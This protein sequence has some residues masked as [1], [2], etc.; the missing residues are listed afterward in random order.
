MSEGSGAGGSSP[1]KFNP[2]SR[3]AKDEEQSKGEDADKTQ[4]DRKAEKLELKEKMRCAQR[5]KDAMKQADHE[6]DSTQT[7][8]EDGDEEGAEQ[9]GRDGLWIEDSVKDLKI[10]TIG[11]V[12]SGKSTLVGVLTKGL[13][14]DGRGKARSRVFN[15][16]HEQEKGQTSSIAQEIMGFS[17]SGD[18]V[19]VDRPGAVTAQSRNS[20]WQQI[21]NESEKLVTFIDLC[22]HERYLKTTIFGLVGLCP[23]YAM[24]I[25][26]ANAG[27]QKMSREHLGIALALRIPFMFIVTK[28]DIAPANV[29][30]ENLNMLRKIAKS[31]AVKKQ[32]VDIKEESDLEPAIKGLAADSLCP[33]FCISSVT[34]EG[35]PLLKRFIQSLPSRIEHSGL[36]RPPSAPTEHHIDSVFSVPGVGITVGGLMRAGVV[37]PNQQLLLG[38]DKSSKFTPVLVKSIHYKRVNSQQVESGQ[39]CS[40]ALRSLVKKEQ[41]KKSSFRKGMVLVDAALQPKATWVFKAEVVILHH[42]TTIRERYQ[43]MIHCGIVRQC[44]F[45]INLST[46]L[47]RTGD[48]AIVTFR[49]CFH[50]EYLNAGSTLLFREGRTKGI[51]R[52]VEL[53]DEDSLQEWGIPIK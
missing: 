25:V 53:V 24:I 18:Q 4:Q 51:G 21:V 7:P 40:F 11:N 19:I 37:R 33:I 39:H 8:S 46:D 10:A 49:F 28:I 41:L 6:D 14:D 43:A 30:E 52:I 31:N 20:A 22:G 32:P 3:S 44:A 5:A 36:F 50:G 45:V 15:F 29:Y 23:D 48:K 2:P 38:P 1:S 16:S 42:A 26:N 35:L 47:L 27:F 34:G 17:S 12:D 9:K 13:L